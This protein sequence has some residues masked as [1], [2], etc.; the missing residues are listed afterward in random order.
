MNEPRSALRSYDRVTFLQGGTAGLTM[1]LIAF[2]A[3]S[4]SL[5]L[6]GVFS[7]AVGVGM[8]SSRIF[9]RFSPRLVGLVMFVARSAALYAAF[10]DMFM[11]AI[12][13]AA[14]GG[15]ASRRL[16]IDLKHR[17][18]PLDPSRLVVHGAWNAVGF[19][20]GATL[21]GLLLDQSMVAQIVAFGVGALALAIYPS[22]TVDTTTATTGL[23][24]GDLVVSVLYS[25]ASN[26]LINATAPVL[27]LASVGPE[28][29]GLS[30]FAFTLGSLLAP[31]AARVLQRVTHPVAVAVGL[32]GVS[33][34]LLLFFPHPLLVL[35]VRFFNGML[36]YAGQGILEMRSQQDGDGRGLESLWTAIAAA[37]ILASFVVPSTVEHF[38]LYSALVWPIAGAL[39]IAAVPLATGKR[40]TP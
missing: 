25:F 2:L 37:S 28:I 14:V 12:I 26:P 3:A 30:S 13:L 40:R 18:G 6:A 32:A 4:R 36:L 35:S 38:G 23:T 5:T 16:F 19:G 1:S 17:V 8:L 11:V 7:A 33:F 20:I 15:S 22:S 9:G 27:L 24:G 29:A 31:R 10:N 21:A 39:L 34:A